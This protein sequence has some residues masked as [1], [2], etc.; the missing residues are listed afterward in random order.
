MQCDNTQTETSSQKT[1]QQIAP[2][3]REKP[4][5][6]YDNNGNI[7]E[8]H[9]KSYR[10]S[11]GSIRSVDSYFYTYDHKNRLIEETKKSFTV[12]G[13]IIF[14]NKSIYNYNK[15]DLKT[16][17]L[18]LVFDINDSI[19]RRARTT[20]DY[21]N[22]GYLVVEKSY[23]N[24]S[25]LKSKIIRKPNEKGDLVSEEFI[26]YKPDGSK[27]DHKKYYYTAHGLDRIEDLMD[28]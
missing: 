28:E 21:N 8:R 15:K 2:P 26:H 22:A 9:A 18:F 16:E 23:F 1:T 24:D 4:R 10:K 7:T 20:F 13:E 25:I 17:I 3:E 5:L 14:K 11:D 12:D 6:I 19:Q 27:K